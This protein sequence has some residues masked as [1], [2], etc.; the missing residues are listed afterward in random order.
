MLGRRKMNKNCRL[1]QTELPLTK[2]K[3][4]IMVAGKTYCAV[5]LA[6]RAKVLTRLKEDKKSLIRHYQLLK[7]E[8]AL[9][10]DLKKLIK[11]GE[12]TDARTKELIKNKKG[13]WQDYNLSKYHRKAEKK[14]NKDDKLKKELFG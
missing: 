8:L 4:G 3:H 14:L 11:L 6:A 2:D 9:I 5:C 13:Y 1:C 7:G 12:D 10:E